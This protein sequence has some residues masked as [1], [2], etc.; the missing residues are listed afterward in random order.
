MARFNLDVTGA[1][2]DQPASFNTPRPQPDCQAS[3]AA[4]RSAEVSQRPLASRNRELP[5]MKETPVEPSIVVI[6]ITAG[7]SSLRSRAGS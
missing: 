6:A 7:W 4:M 1:S 5:V 2:R 3:I